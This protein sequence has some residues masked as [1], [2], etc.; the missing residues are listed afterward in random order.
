MVKVALDWVA[1][2]SGC[3]VYTM[4]WLPGTE[5]LVLMAPVLGSTVTFAGPEKLPPVGCTV[6]A[7]VQFGAPWV[8]QAVGFG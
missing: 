6:A 4:V 8:W 2:E 7:F 5:A 3:G 1:Q